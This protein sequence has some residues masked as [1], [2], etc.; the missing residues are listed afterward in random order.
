MATVWKGNGGDRP[1]G[2]D[3]GDHNKKK[4][5]PKSGIHQSNN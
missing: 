5:G 3:G 2:G 4:P 1:G